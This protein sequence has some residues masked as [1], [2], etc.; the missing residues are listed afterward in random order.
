MLLI[1]EECTREILT[2]LVLEV[3]EEQHVDGY[4]ESGEVL[5]YAF[6]RGIDLCGNDRERVGRVDVFGRWVA[7]R[8]LVILVQCAGTLAIIF[9]EPSNIVGIA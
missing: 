6:S 9:V 5:D 4:S 8:R 1:E 2:V 7:E 3:A